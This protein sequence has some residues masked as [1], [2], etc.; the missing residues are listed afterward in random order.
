MKAAHLTTLRDQELLLGE[1]LNVLVLKGIMAKT[2]NIQITN[3]RILM[4]PTKTLALSLGLIG[5]L[6][7]HLMKQDRLQE[8]E[9]QNVVNVQKSSH[10]VNKNI[11]LIELAGGKSFKVSTGSVQEMIDALDRARNTV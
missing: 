9:I 8:H 2:F 1:F 5:L 4:Q 6:A 11:V 10:G 3:Q 7:Q